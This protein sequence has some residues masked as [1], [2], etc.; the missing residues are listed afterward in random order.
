MS[1][2]EIKERI[3]RIDNLIRL[4]S[5]GTPKDLAEIIKISE[6]QVYRLIDIMK[7]MGAEIEYSRYKQSYIYVKP[8]KLQLGYLHQKLNQ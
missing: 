3:E 7:D 4:E 2:L 1:F 5:T 6:R 8:V